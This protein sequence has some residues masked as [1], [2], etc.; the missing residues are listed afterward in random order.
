MRP[1]LTAIY[2]LQ[3]LRA[4]LTLQRIS[5]YD[6]INTDIRNYYLICS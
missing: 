2:H 5:R 4:L 1:T 3:L 6:T